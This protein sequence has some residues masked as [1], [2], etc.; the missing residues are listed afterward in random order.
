MQLDF[1]AVLRRW[2][3]LAGVVT[4]IC[5]L[6]YAAVQHSIRSGANDP[7]VQL[8][9]DAVR[10]LE[11]GDALD[12]AVPA[13]K[14]DIENSLAPFVIALD[15][16]GQPLAGSG[17]YRGRLLVP[18]NGVLEYV[19]VNGEERVTLQPSPSVRI[20]SV[21]IRTSAKPVAFVLA[22]R[23]LREAERG[24]HYTR[25]AAAVAWAIALGAALVLIMLGELAL[26][27]RR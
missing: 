5:L 9:E 25:I 8:A 18:P 4:V 11:R 16:T 23:S 15:S 22:G 6:V 17:L 20:A 26:R 19:R 2:L 14:V 12:A 24:E 13:G 21:V 3:P 1:S 7:Q 10:V 27:P